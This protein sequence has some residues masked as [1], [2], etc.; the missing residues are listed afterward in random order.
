[1]IHF[2]YYTNDIEAST[3]KGFVSLDQFL[4]AQKFPKPHILNIFE[5]ISQAEQQGDKVNKAKLKEQLYSFTPCV[6]VAQRRRYADIL[7]F[8]G[9]LVLDFD[10]IDNAEDFK[11]YLFEKYKYIVAAWL[12]PSQKGVKALVNIPI[13]TTTDEFKSYFFGIAIHMWKYNG[14]DVSAQNCVLPLFQSYDKDLLSR[15]DYTLF[16]E[17]GI[18]VNDFDNATAVNVTV[19]YD[20][21]EAVIIKMIDTAL[22][23]ITDNGHPQLRSLCIAIGGY[24]A[25][26]Y[27]DKHTAIGYICNRITTHNYLKKGVAGYQRT[28]K[29]AIEWGVTKPLNLHNHE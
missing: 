21:K 10:H 16:E 3:A 19:N 12:S 8:T 26:N 23:K 14:F 25:N 9:L 22:D 7:N 18:K 24:I 28:A 15:Q 6:Q 4:R 17:K 29:K 13:C 20:N 5:Q 1:M 27:I 11:Q 2:Q